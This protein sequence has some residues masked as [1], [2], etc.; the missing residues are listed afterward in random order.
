[1][2]EIDDEATAVMRDAIVEVL[3]EEGALSTRTTPGSEDFFYYPVKRPGVK[4]GFWG[5]G[6]NLTP[7][8]HH[9]DMHF[10]LDSLEIGVQIFKA[11]VRKVL[12]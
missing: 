6:T 7:G 3:G 5:L 1:A 4:A 9:P 8:L 10:D 2:A 12:G 11:C